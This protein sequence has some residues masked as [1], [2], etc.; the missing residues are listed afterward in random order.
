MMRNQC[1]ERSEHFTASLNELHL[2][3]NVLV[4]PFLTLSGK[5]AYPLFIFLPQQGNID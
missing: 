2:V 4:D 1:V 3:A 5:I